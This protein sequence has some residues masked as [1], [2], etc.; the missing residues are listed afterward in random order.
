MT[1]CFIGEKAI[2]C[3]S[4]IFLFLIVVFDAIGSNLQLL[5]VLIIVQS[6]LFFY[7]VFFKKHLLVITF[8]ILAATFPIY[9]SVFWALPISAFENTSN[10]EYKSKVIVLFSFFL[11]GFHSVL[12][13]RHS[14]FDI[15]FN[16]KFSSLYFYLLCLAL[17]F[18]SL[19]FGMSGESIL[20]SGQYDLKNLNKSPLHEYFVLFY[21]MLLVN[22]YKYRLKKHIE[23][24]ILLYFCFKSLLFG[25][26]IEVVQ[27]LFVFVMLKYN[28]LQKVQWYYLSAM[29][30]LAYLS[31]TFLG[32]VRESPQF[33][34]SAIN[35]NLDFSL[36]T[37]RSGDEKAW[38]GGTFGDVW[39]SS[40]RLLSLVDNDFLDFSLRLES[41]FSFLFNAFAPSNFWPLHANLS[42]FLQSSFP[43]PG[44]SFSFVQFYVWLGYFGP[45]FNGLFLAVAC[46]S[47]FSRNPFVSF[48]SFLVVVTFPRWFLYNPVALTKFC[49][50]GAVLILLVTYFEKKINKRF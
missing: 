32:V 33:V 15:N 19:I 47:I 43:S 12:S 1:M 28:F 30:V 46:N 20:S 49:L 7:V 10:L 5:V 37:F 40:I 8:F 39:Y 44:G 25:G 42:A 48:Y 22:S 24:F 29:I 11:F 21:S 34:I 31:M 23:L 2:L 36:L 3:L 38:V 4:L 45:F 35:G 26:R 41:F 18:L 50:I 13:T 27:V 14:Q 17:C 16:F 9:E 6:F